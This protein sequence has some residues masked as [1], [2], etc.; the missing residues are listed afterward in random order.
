MNKLKYI[1]A[2]ATPCGGGYCPLCGAHDDTE[3]ENNEPYLF[4][5]PLDEALNKLRQVDKLQAQVD[6]LT[7]IA[8]SKRVSFADRIRFVNEIDE[9]TAE[10]D[11]LKA[12]NEQLHTL[13]SEQAAKIDELQEQVDAKDNCIENI[14]QTLHETQARARNLADECYRYRLQCERYEAK[15]DKLGISERTCH[16]VS[17]YA[18]EFKCSE[19][20]AIWC[21]EDEACEPMLIVDGVAEYPSYCQNCGCKVVSE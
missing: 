17:G 21:V 9:L 12:N 18:S 15:T 3:P 14:M 10:R 4:G 6:K 8:E 5:M 16:N 1:E 19:C 7:Q 20:G 11:N 13:T 2:E